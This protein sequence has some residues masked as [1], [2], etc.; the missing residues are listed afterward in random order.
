VSIAFF[1][2]DKTLLSINSG[3]LWFKAELRE[4]NITFVQAMQAFT[5]LSLYHLGFAKLEQS[6]LTSIAQLEGVE[7]ATVAART[8]TFYEREVRQRFRPRARHVV[9]DHRARGDKLVLLTSSSNYLAE[10][11][12]RELG[13][14]HVLCNRFEV[15]ATGLYTGRPHGP[16]C[17]GPGKLTLGRAYADAAGVPLSACSF[18]TD[19]ASDLPMMEAVGRPVAVHPDPRLRRIAQQRGWEIA[20]WSLG[21]ADRR[22]A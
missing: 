3:S 17:F 20:D 8:L 14:D 11:V 21:P 9:D 4:G 7:E 19:S 12:M 1:D 16:L 18:Y 15:N 13:F 2:L 6:L 5:W 10:P 22:A